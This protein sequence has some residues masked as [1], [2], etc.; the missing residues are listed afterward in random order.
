M[1][2]PAYLPGWTALRHLLPATGVAPCCDARLQNEYAFVAHLGSVS[3]HAALCQGCGLAAMARAESDR[4]VH[5]DRLTQELAPRTGLRSSG[6]S[7][8]RASA[9]PGR[10]LSAIGC[11]RWVRGEKPN[12][13]SLS[14]R[15]RE[16]NS[17]P[18]RWDLCS[19]RNAAMGRAVRP[20]LMA[21]AF[22]PWAQGRF[23]LPRNRDWE[24]RLENQLAKGPGRQGHVCLGLHRVALSGRQQG[25]LHSGSE[26]EA[27]WRPW[28]KTRA[29]CSGAARA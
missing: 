2:A 3:V 10:Q 25:H 12:T 13:F 20:P 28:T 19:A 27:P 21:T 29:R 18:P 15:M 23:G 17:G 22:T 6:P 24:A 1:P 11:S 26:L 16:K 5:R 4:R 8:M 9:I 14:T 7:Q